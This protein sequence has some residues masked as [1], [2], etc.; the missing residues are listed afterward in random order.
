MLKKI[1]ACSQNDAPYMVIIKYPKQCA[2]IKVMSPT[3]Q[4]KPITTNQVAFLVTDDNLS[5]H[6][7]MLSRVNISIILPQPYMF[8]TSMLHSLR[9]GNE[10]YNSC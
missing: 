7:E 9:I 6:N 3:I 10:V 2:N 4:A 5:S 1:N 8:L